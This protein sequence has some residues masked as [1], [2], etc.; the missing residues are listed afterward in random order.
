RSELEDECTK[1]P[2]SSSPWSLDD[3]VGTYR[4]KGFGTLHIERRSDYLWFRIEDYSIS[5]SPLARYSSLCFEHQRDQDVPI[6]EPEPLTEIKRKFD[7]KHQ[8]VG[9]VIWIGVAGSATRDW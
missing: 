8:T 6:T 1:S 4:H 7:F 3:F 2:I 9:S 5:N